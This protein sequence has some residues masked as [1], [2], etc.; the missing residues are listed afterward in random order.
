MARGLAQ[1]AGVHLAKHF[2]LVVPADE[3]RRARRLEID[4]EPAPRADRAPDRYRLGLALRRHRLERLVVDHVPRRPVRLLAGEERTRRS[5]RLQP[6]RGVDDVTGD[7]ALAQLG[8]GSERDDR[9]AGVDRGTGL[10]LELGHRVQD[11]QPRSDGPLGVVLVRDGGA[12]CGHH[13]VADELLDRPAEALDLRLRT[14]VVRLQSR[15]HVFRIGRLG[16]SREADEVDE[17]D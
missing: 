2:E 12:E 6:R 9:L 13:C 3:R 1:R 7:E 14:R 10:Q 4:S 11:D 17:Q 15:S 16:R 5:R 8:P